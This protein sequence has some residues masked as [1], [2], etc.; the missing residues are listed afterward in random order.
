[1][2]RRFLLRVLS[3]VS[4]VGLIV[5]GGCQRSLDA[6]SERAQALAQRLLIVDTHIDA[7][8]RVHRSH[9]DLLVATDGQFDYPRARA[10][11]LDAPFMSIYIPAGVDAAGEGMARAHALI[12]IVEDLVSRAPEK[13]ALA[14]SVADVERNFDAGLISLPMGMENVG[15][16]GAEFEH[17]QTLYDRGIRYVTPAHSRSNVFSDSS[18]DVDERWEGL[19][20]AGRELVAKLNAIGIMIDVSHLSDRAFWQV[21]ELSRTPVIASHSATRRFV[22]GFHRNIDDD[23]IRAMGEHAGVVQINFGS[24]YVSAESR[25]SQEGSRKAYREFLDASGHAG[26]SDEA[27]TFMTQYLSEHPLRRANV[28]EVLDHFDHVV[29]LAGIDH[30]GIG[31]DYDGV[32]DTL[33]IGLEDVSTY[34]NL[35][36]G[37]LARGYSEAD[38]EKIVGGN[39]LR[40]WRAVERFSQEQRSSS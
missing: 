21:M 1:M 27:R 17:L 20:P 9:E 40:V 18:Y 2:K 38:I 4:V 29:A 11:G 7:P 16:I 22:P 30:V 32:G 39:L 5:L 12:D 25:G 33:P 31:S 10:G 13:F 24:T 6:P 23:M 26:N 34:P 19:S 15:P 28:D 8:T 36:E 3:L 37:L 35:I 14:Y